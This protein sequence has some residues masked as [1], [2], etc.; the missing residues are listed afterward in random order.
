MRRAEGGGREISLR[1]ADDGPAKPPQAGVSGRPQPARDGSPAQ[2]SR[3]PQMRS[4]DGVGR[5][6]S[7]GACHSAPARP[8]A[9]T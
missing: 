1:R 9:A 5:A 3:S 7:N 6:S 8:A 2:R 4:R